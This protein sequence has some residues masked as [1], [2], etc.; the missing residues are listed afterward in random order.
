MPGIGKSRLVWELM[1]AVEAEPDFVTW[2][3]GRSLPYGDGVTFWALG[4]MVKAQAGILDS[5]TAQEAD[6]K[7]HATVADLIGDPAEAAW[8]EQHVRALA[9]LEAPAGSGGGSHSEAVAAWRRFLEALADQHPLV[10]VFED[11][12]WA[13]DP[14]LDFIDHLV[15]WATDVPMLV[16][17]TARPELLD[18]RG[19]WGGGKRNAITVALSPLAD[20]DIARL[21]GSLLE[22]ALLPA[23]TQTTLLTTAAGNPLYAEEYVRMLIDRGHLQHIDGR[24]RLTVGARLP[25][26]ES[27]QGLI[28]ARLDDLPAEQKRLLQDASV[29]GKVVWLGALAAMSGIDRFQARSTCTRW[30]G[31]RCC[32]A[33]GDRRWPATPSTPSATC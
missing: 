3:Q 19:G 33:S 31:G 2:R 17:C 22:Q 23:E 15:D 20:A 18:R 8:V 7:L 9:G 11:M 16:V 26:P 24:W 32:A 5:D 30:S 4:E 13:D 6:G 10:L 27:V 28:A 14:M 1:Q 25:V 12:H 21:I 29:L